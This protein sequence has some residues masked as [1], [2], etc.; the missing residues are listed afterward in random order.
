MDLSLSQSAGE[1]GSK[2]AKPR[3]PEKGSGAFITHQLES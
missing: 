3:P 2:R 1:G